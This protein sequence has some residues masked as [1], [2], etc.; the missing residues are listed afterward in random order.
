MLA[1]IM[2]MGLI[3]SCDNNDHKDLP[4]SLKLDNITAKDSAFS[5]ESCVITGTAEA[6][7]KIDK[8]QVFKSFPW[9]NSTSEVEVAGSGVY[10][11]TESYDQIGDTLTTYH[12]SITISN[13][14]TASNLR[15]QLTDKNGKTTS[16]NYKI[17]VRQSNIL[18]YL[19]IQMGGWTSDYKSG[20]DLD[21]GNTY[22][23]SQVASAASVLDL[24]F[25]KAEFASTDLDADVANGGVPRF[26]DT[27]TRFAKTSFSSADFDKFEND[28]Q[29]ASMSG[30]LH[31]I[32]IQAGDVVFFQTKSGRKGLLNVISMTSPTGDLLVSLKIQKE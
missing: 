26:A 25:D 14:K 31:L 27:G 4:L 21:T 28:E 32:P 6:L 5:G 17:T 30:T 18:S 11:G 23:S 15:I 3:S 12:F 2:L 1:V 22:G 19:N 16:V 10:S 29:F 7:G 8:I 13:V 24:F 20:I 9:N